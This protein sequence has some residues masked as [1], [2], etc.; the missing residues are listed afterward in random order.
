MELYFSLD[1]I[2]KMS[3]ILKS[4]KMSTFFLMKA[5]KNGRKEAKVV[6]LFFLSI[7]LIHRIITVP[8][9]PQ[10]LPSWQYEQCRWTR[11]HQYKLW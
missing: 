1:C 11:F 10:S 6:K 9:K 3:F 2:S 8:Q 7:K 5:S 4:I